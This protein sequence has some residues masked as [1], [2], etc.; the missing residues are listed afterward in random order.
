MKFDR[1]SAPG[2]DGRACERHRHVVALRGRDQR[3]RVQLADGGFSGQPFLGV[4][5]AEPVLEKVAT[6]V[7]GSGQ[8]KLIVHHLQRL[9]PLFF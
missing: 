3:E 5:A 6:A 4:Y 9:V 1:V 2:N 7:I 8:L